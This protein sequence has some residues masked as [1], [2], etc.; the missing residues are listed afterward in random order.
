MSLLRSKFLKVGFV[1]PETT[2]VIMVI[3]PPKT[4]AITC[5]AIFAAKPLSKAPSSLEEPTNI[6]F[7]E[8]TRPLISSGVFICNIV[9]RI[10][11]EIQSAAQLINKA[12]TLNQKTDDT[13]KAII[14]NPKINTETSIFF[15]VFLWIGI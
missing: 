5:P 2:V 9:C 6:E 14:L 11:I 7:T 4:T 12:R 13:P 8:E 1:I 10:T 15:P 3:L